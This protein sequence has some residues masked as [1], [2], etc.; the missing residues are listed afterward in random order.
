M[1]KMPIVTIELIE[2][3]SVEQKREMAK[4]ITETITEITKIPKDAVEIIF[5]DMKKENYSKGG[6]LA[7]D[8]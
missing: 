4:K 1:L 5:N 7:I 2:G 8:M 6:L 3:R